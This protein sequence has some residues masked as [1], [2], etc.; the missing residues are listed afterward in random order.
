MRKSQPVFKFIDGIMSKTKNGPIKI[1]LANEQRNRMVSA[2]YIC[3]LGVTCVLSQSE[4]SLKVY[5]QG[6]RKDEGVKGSELSLKQHCSPTPHNDETKFQLLD[7][8]NISSKL[9]SIEI[10]NLGKEYMNTITKHVFMIHW[11]MQHEC[12]EEQ[13]ESF[14]HDLQ[15]FLSKSTHIRKQFEDSPTPH[16]A[17][18]IVPTLAGKILKE[19]P[20]FGSAKPPVTSD[21][22]G[23]DSESID[24]TATLS[25]I[26]GGDEYEIEVEHPSPYVAHNIPR[27]PIDK[28][29]LKSGIP[30][31]STSTAAISHH[32]DY[33]P[34]RE[35]GSQIIPR[36]TGD[37][38]TADDSLLHPP[39]KVNSRASATANLS[40]SM[41]STSIQ[42]SP[43]LDIYAETFDE[44]NVVGDGEVNIAE[45]KSF[46]ATH[47]YYF[48][49]EELVDFVRDFD[50]DQ[51][52]TINFGEF[53]HALNVIEE[54]SLTS[55][56]FTDQTP[57]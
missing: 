13:S 19:E 40:T 34:L 21:E 11:R 48:T 20:L 1:D 5:V 28:E 52:G 55:S 3:N 17:P 10:Y 22:L 54:E 42:S 7:L 12:T 8:R 18:V 49:T 9:K 24:E 44:M 45:L 33:H 2:L 25:S 56:M 15:E 4:E 29:S 6:A 23:F 14:E 35:T 41:M 30:A 37:N 57:R 46:F 27:L 16:T 36:S 32:H 53:V 31:V 26:S 39:T 38:V 43:R 50:L 47:G 51:S